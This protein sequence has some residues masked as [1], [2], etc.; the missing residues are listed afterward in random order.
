MCTVAT[1]VLQ[2]ASDVY[3][4]VSGEVVEVNQ[5]LVDEPAKVRHLYLIALNLA[6]PN[7]KEWLTVWPCTLRLAVSISC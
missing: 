1:A 6:L 7:C 3:S 4:P 5:A 2:A